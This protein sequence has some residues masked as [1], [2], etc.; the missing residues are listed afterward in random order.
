[1]PLLAI[2]VWLLADL[3]RYA[4]AAGVTLGVT[5]FFLA[6]VPRQS[7]RWVIY[8]CSPT[9]CKRL[10]TRVCRRHGW[11]AAW[12]GSGVL[13]VEPIHLQVSS[14]ML[15]LL[16]SVTLHIEA[17]TPEQ[18]QASERLIQTLRQEIR[19]EAM[20]PSPTG[21]SLVV[22]GT[23]LLG[24]PMWYFFH[25]FSTIVEVVRRIFAA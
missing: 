5:V 14:E 18:N 2:P 25:H 9:Q 3:G 7:R 22:L 19:E 11:Q 20:L 13:E 23:G 24:L 4:L 1:M 17:N 21:A 16:R 8:N 10:L 15:P 6:L 12:G